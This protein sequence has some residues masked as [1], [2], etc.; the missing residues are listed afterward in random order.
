MA[1]Y[2]SIE[3]TDRTWNPTRGC[4]K[5][6]PGCAHCYAALFA[7]RFEG[8]KENAY[9]LGFMPRIVPEKLIDPLLIVKPSEF[10]VNSMSDLFHQA[11]EDDYISDVCRVMQVAS[12]HRFQVLTKRSERLRVFLNSHPDFAQ[13]PNVIWGVSVEN[14]KYGIPRME[15][16]RN[17]GAR[18]KFLSIEPL[19]EDLGQLN[20]RGFHWAI[21]GGE[22]GPKSRE[23]K[24]EWVLKIRRQCLA[25][26]VPFFFKQ[27]GGVNKKKTGRLLRGR[28]YNER[29][30]WPRP[31]TVDLQAQIQFIEVLNKQYGPIKVPN[32]LR[33][34][35]T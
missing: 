24:E 3:W 21:V 9:E 19:L 8:V 10:F 29:P 32:R 16:L 31:Q 28:E 23:M 1:Q 34:T 2:S 27:W 25:A 33:R 18:F 6:S 11:F 12:Q 26:N 22:S 4:D 35:A 7:H 15:D 17:S 13:L 5:I 20:L 14:R 30:L